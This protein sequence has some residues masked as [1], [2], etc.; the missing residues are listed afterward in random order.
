MTQKLVLLIVVAVLSLPGG[1]FM[2]ALMS[3]PRARFASMLGGIIGAA[4][5]GAGIFYFIT[6]AHVYIDMLSY[7][8]G[9]FFACSMGVFAGALIANWAVGLGNRGP[10]TSEY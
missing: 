1:L 9:S 8:L 10:A 6:K 3:E 7:G 2:A 5:V 4:A